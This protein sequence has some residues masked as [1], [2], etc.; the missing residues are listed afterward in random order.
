MRNSGNFWFGPETNTLDNII[1]KWYGEIGCKCK[2]DSE[3]D[4]VTDFV[5]TV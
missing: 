3:F 2:I 5:S 1:L 4:P